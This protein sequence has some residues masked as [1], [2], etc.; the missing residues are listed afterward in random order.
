[1][2]IPKQEDFAILLMSELA[3]GYGK[4]LV[5][6]SSVATT[7]GVSALFLKKI[8]RL[9]RQAGL[10]TSKEGIGGGYALAKHPSRISVWEI[11]QAASGKEVQRITSR[12]CP[13]YAACLPQRINKTIG[14]SVEKGL[15][16]ITLLQC[17]S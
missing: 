12:V 3:N 11:M 9:L 13:L 10:V 14:D 7:H 15:R 5:S 16:G 2:K 6:L 8:A 17:L 1:M 4:K